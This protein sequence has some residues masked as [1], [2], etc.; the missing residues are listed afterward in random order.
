MTR[1][2]LQF[3]PVFFGVTFLAFL[4]IRAAP[5]DAA[6]FFLADRGIDISNDALVKTRKDLGLDKTIAHQYAAYLSAILSG[7]L[8]TSYITKEPVAKEL[9]RRF[10]VT[11]A[12]SVPSLAAALGIAF[13][14]GAISALQQNRVLDKI[15]RFLSI[16]GISLPS[17][18]L[19]VLLMVVLGVKLRL[20]PVFG[21]AAPL[22]YIMPGITLVT[23]AAAYYTR[24]LR[25]VLLEEFSKEYIQAAKAQGLPLFDIVRSSLKNASLPVLTSLGMSLAG[26]LGGHIVIEKIFALPGMGSYLIDGIVQRDY[27]VVDGCVLLYAALFSCINLCAD[28]MCAYIHPLYEK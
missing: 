21:A 6:R 12:V 13:F 24:F 9:V 14:L 4:L 28:I 27:A 5:G 18:C 26:L 15:I 10:R 16:A 8:G 3:I 23:A 2:L 19:A 22:H 25:G 17:F 7:N 20:L 11:L 1:R